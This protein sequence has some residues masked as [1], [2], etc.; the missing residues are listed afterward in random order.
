MKWLLPVV[1]VL[2]AMS[3]SRGAETPGVK[4]DWMDHAAPLVDTGLSFG[5]P[6]ARG[7]V[8]KGAS[9]HLVDAKGQQI[10]LQTW[11]MAYWPDGSLKWTGHAIAAAAGVA[12]P[13]TIEPGEAAAPKSP[14]KVTEDDRSI[15]IDT[16]ALTCAIYKAHR[17]EGASGR[18]LPIS[19]GSI[20]IGEKKIA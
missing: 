5:V 4:V 8:Q 10:P 11:P 19:I 13:F 18:P 12:G 17:S 7:A 16:G 3:T 6:W 15:T 20:T 2:L 14:V 1:C 9:L